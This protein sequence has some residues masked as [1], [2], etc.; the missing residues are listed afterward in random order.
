MEAKD[1]WGGARPNTGGKRA[2]AGRIQQR[3]ALS[4]EAA[5]IL[6]EIVRLRNAECPQGHYTPA[7]LVDD[8]ISIEAHKLGIR[9]LPNE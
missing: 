9:R 5:R 2:G 4:F 3:V 8:L 6:R 1:G 7:N